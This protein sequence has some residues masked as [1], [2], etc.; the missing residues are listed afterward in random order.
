VQKLYFQ[1]AAA[2]QDVST[3]GGVAGA[4]ASDGL[5]ILKAAQVEPELKNAADS[6]GK[7]DFPVAAKSQQSVIKG[8]SALLEKLDETQGLIDSDREEALRLVRE[9][10]KKQQQLRELTKQTELN[11]KT[12]EPLIEQQAQIHKEL[13]KLAEAL[14]KYPTTEPLLEQAKSRAFEATASLFEEKKPPA[15]D[16]QN[17]VIG[18]LAQIEKV[19]E[20][21]LD[22]E[23]SSKSAD[24]LAED[25]KRLEELKKQLAEA[26]KEQ[27]K[28]NAA[29]AN[30]PQ[31]AAQ[32]EKQV[33]EDLAK[34][35]TLGDL[36]SSVDAKLND[37]K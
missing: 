20:Q 24:E 2:L 28:A 7:A 3:W 34:T 33:A 1:L 21:G 12:A 17:E 36:P 18:A 4:G 5:R 13:G 10:L 11:E 14:S 32:Q 6:L 29:A 27:A 8:L 22:L 35:D 26:Q 25:V 31:E 15:L 19:L 30:K 23:Q 16:Q 37:A 9:M